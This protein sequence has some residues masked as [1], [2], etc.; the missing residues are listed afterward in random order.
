MGITRPP[1]RRVM[2]S[3][4]ATTGAIVALTVVSFSLF[5]Q[6]F[7]ARQESKLLADSLYAMC[8]SIPEAIPG[9]NMAKPN[10]YN[11]TAESHPWFR[12]QRATR[13]AC[14]QHSEQLYDAQQRSLQRSSRSK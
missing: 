8:S 12:L 9:L 6:Y 10:P 11:P 7:H 1:A 4:V 3:S 2:K 5:W 14:E 13:T